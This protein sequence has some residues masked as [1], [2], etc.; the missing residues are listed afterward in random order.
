MIRFE[1]NS[2]SES[3][4]RTLHTACARRAREAHERKETML[5][6]IIRGGQVA[7]PHGAGALDIAIQGET[8]A[9][10]AA[11]AAL[12]D[13]TAA[14]IIDASGKIVVPGGVDAHIHCKWPTPVGEFSAPPAHVSRA[15]LFGGTT[16]FVDF[17]VWN[18]GQT[19]QQAVELRDGDWSGQCCCDYAYHVLLHGD[20]PPEVVEQLPETI[21]AGFPSVKMYTTDVRP[22]RTGWKMDYGNIWEVLQHMPSRRKGIGGGCG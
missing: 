10:V 4:E 22:Q 20:V 18:S 17:A 12:R 15:A 9:A 19:L 5:D 16:T 13:M 8:I 21:Q 2:F 14:R 1:Y 7:T 3:I 11:P 6:L